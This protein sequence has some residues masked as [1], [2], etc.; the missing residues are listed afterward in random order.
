MVDKGRCQ[1]GEHPRRITRISAK[2][3]A[4]T[5]APQPQCSRLLRKSGRQCLVLVHGVLRDGLAL[6]VGARPRKGR[7]VTRVGLGHHPGV[8]VR[9]RC[10]EA[11][12]WGARTGRNRRGQLGLNLDAR[13]HTSSP[14]R[15]A[16][17]SRRAVIVG[18]SQ[19]LQV[20]EILPARRAE[21]K[22][23]EK[24][25]VQ[26]LVGSRMSRAHR[27]VGVA[28]FLIQVPSE[29]QLLDVSPNLLALVAIGLLTQSTTS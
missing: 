5:T 10:C 23:G 21:E 16:N 24:W 20:D 8:C 13:T 22:V 17:M 29:N 18:K 25:R 6:R 28:A 1:K 27:D 15:D 26:P 14:W 12:G 11:S 4:S 2:G 19:S 3:R 9:V 7:L